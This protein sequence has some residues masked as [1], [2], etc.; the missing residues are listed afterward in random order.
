MA[1]KPRFLDRVLSSLLTNVE[2]RAYVRRGVYA[3]I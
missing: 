2:P 1:M 3:T